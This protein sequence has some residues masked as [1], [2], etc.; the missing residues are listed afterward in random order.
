VNSRP[1]RGRRA[2][3]PEHAEPITAEPTAASPWTV[4]L[5]WTPDQNVGAVSAMPGR[6]PVWAV[7]G[8]LRAGEDAET[9]AAEY[10]LTPEEVEVLRHL[11]DDLAPNPPDETEPT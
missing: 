8:S 5:A 4:T 6:A 3:G 7:V 11:A 9:V 2:V 1:G 10:G